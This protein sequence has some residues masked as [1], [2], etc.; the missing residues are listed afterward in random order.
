MVKTL[1]KTAGGI[2][3]VIAIFVIFLAVFDWNVLRGYIGEKVTEKT[4]R[5]FSINGDLD[6]DFFTFPP[7]IR[8]EKLRLANAPWGTGSTMLDIH[9]LDFRINLIA[10]LKGDVVLPEVALSG[11]QVLLEKSADGK[12][13]WILGQDQQSGKTPRIERLKVDQGILIFRDP[14]ITTDITANISPASKM[15]DVRQVG[16]KFSAQG[17]FKGLTF[18]A[19]GEGGKILSLLDT[20]TPYPL[21]GDMQLGA[22][23][24]SV[25]GTITGL[26]TLS[27]VDMRLGIRGEDLSALFPLVAIPFPASPPY[28]I[29]GRLVRKGDSW[30]F[31]DF[32][33]KV[34]DSDLGGDFNVNVSGRKP[35]VRAELVSR[36]LDI[37]DLG[38]VIGA[39]PQTGPGE[40]ASATQKKAA[41]KLAG[42]VHV[43]PDTKFKLD[44]LRTVDADVKLN[45][46]SIIGPKLPL[47]DLTVHLVLKDG[48]LELQPL[49]FGVAGGNIISNI[50]LNI[51]NETATAH[52]DITFK[53]LSLNKLFPTVKLTKTSMGMIGGQAKFTGTGN[54]FAQLLAT[55]N[56]RMGVSMGGGRISNLLLEIMGI[57]GAEIIK[58]LFGGDRTVLVRCMVADFKVIDGLMR[59]EV[60][61]LDTTDTNISGQGSINLKD[62]S[63]D[64]KLRPLPKDVSLLSARAPLFVRGT[65]KNPK[66]A[67]DMERVAARAGAAVVL[68]TLLTPLA[69]IIPLIETGPGKDS[70]CKDLIAHLGKNSP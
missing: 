19:N 29:Q 4:G 5:E 47:D 63:I 39:P 16:I 65:F 48:K 59:T 38:G 55:A 17:K 2:V 10:L 31:N 56:G 12:R 18:H 64:L 1:T 20:K 9:R 14:A 67:P 23:R 58:F 61:V 22:T 42:S 35:F 34:G 32:V 62:E 49:N 52:T 60:L 69:A 24:I 15:Q 28:E 41:Q 66:F 25:G 8:A 3:A 27:A 21:Q 70:D 33:G 30:Q 43:L 51:G 36:K 26:S 68:G 50:V 57:D 54:S 46:K 6:V 53:K 40:T 45:A 37:D 13:N 7:R 44:R 11:A